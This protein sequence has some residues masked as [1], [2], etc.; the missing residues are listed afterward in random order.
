M[1][2]S[3]GSGSFRAYAAAP[4]RRWLPFCL[5]FAVILAVIVGADLG[6]LGFLVRYVH[7]IPYFDKILHA[8]LIGLLALALNHALAWRRLRLAGFGLFLGS[9]LIGLGTTL[10]EF[11]QIWIPGRTFDW[12]DLAANWTGVLLASAVGW[13]RRAKEDCRDGKT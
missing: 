4:M 7:Q 6:R 11:S 10:E 5:Y 9:V 1:P 12:G 2:Q 3:P 8:L 13:W